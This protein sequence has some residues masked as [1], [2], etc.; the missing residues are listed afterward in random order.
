M[1]TPPQSFPGAPLPRPHH[2]WSLDHG[3]SLAAHYMRDLSVSTPL[4]ALAVLLTLCLLISSRIPGPYPGFSLTLVGLGFCLAALSLRSPCGVAVSSLLLYV[5]AAFFFLFYS[6]LDADFPNPAALSRWTDQPRPEYAS[7]DDVQ[8]AAR[9]REKPE[10]PSPSSV[11]SW[12]REPRVGFIVDVEFLSWPGHRQTSSGALWLR[13]PGT[14][15]DYPAGKL[16]RARGKLRSIPVA[17]NPGEAA[18]MAYLVRKGVSG[19]FDCREAPLVEIAEG[20]IWDTGGWSLQRLVSPLKDWATARLGYLLE[21]EDTGLA[22]ALLLGNTRAVERSEWEKF[23]KTGTIHALAISG[24]HLVVAGSIIYWLLA[25]MR[26]GQT[27]NLLLSTAFVIVYALIT[28]AQPSA[29]RASIMVAAFCAAVLLN[30]KTPAANILCL[31]WILIALIQPA[32]LTSAGCQLSFLAVLLLDGWQRWRLRE[33]APLAETASDPEQILQRLEQSLRPWWRKAWDAG[34]RVLGE[35]YLV[36][37]WVWCGLCPLI[38]WHTGLISLS[39]LLL[40]PPIALCCTAA[41]VSGMLAVLLPIPFLDRLLAF[42]A[43]RFLDWTRFLADIGEDLPLSWLYRP[44]PPLWFLAIWLVFIVLVLVPRRT[45]MTK[46][47]SFLAFSSLLLAISYLPIRWAP[48]QLLIHVL[49]VGHGT[50]VLIEEP[51]GRVVLYDAGSLVSGDLTGKLISQVLWHKNIKHLD[52]IIL[53]HADTDH[54]NAVSMLLER[55]SVGKLSMGPSF[56]KRDDKQ[57]AEFREKMIQKGVAMDTI[58]RGS[59]SGNEVVYSVLHP[60]PDD[61]NPRTQNL[62]SLVIAIEHFGKTV[63][64]TGDLEPPATQRLLGQENLPKNLLAM[65]APHHGSPAANPDYLWR[66][67]SPRLVFSSEGE[68]SRRTRAPGGAL[69][70]EIPLWKTSEKGMIT[71]KV[72]PK[73]AR[74]TA[75]ATAEIMALENLRANE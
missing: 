61:E 49:A 56:R 2:G 3:L 10:R 14:P 18:P 30:R 53:S 21:G 60:E 48:Q 19:M 67:F 37:A 51:Q 6:R 75:Y 57:A 24:Q 31:A 70:K 1:P 9:V 59:I 29:V 63:L 34:L 20:S 33:R 25:L 38:W 12:S 40:G 39:A 36:N 13:C 62:G 58:A 68:E 50:A 7:R 72:G 16:L 41:L 66:R 43:N 42:A 65:M 26:T 17:M 32:D 28:G 74:A 64:L 73:T 4:F 46:R 52:E 11:P 71:L 69:A 8:I 44:P 54:L 5:A 22:E 27:V 15:E 47:L 23:R 55:F 45:L 35:S